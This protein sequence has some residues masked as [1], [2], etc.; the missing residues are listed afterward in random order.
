MTV[1]T[2][3]DDDEVAE[4]ASEEVGDAASE[5]EPAASNLGVSRAAARPKFGRKK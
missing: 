1:E 5:L 3:T 4:K 2:R